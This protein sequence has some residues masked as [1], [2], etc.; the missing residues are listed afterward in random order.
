MKNLILAVVIAISGSSCTSLPRPEV[1]TEKEND[2]ASLALVRASSAKAGNPYQRLSRVDVRYDGEWANFATKVQPV[3]TDREFRV[4]SDETYYPSSSKVR[5]VYRG[6]AGEKIVTRT[7]KSISIVRNGKKVS[8]AEELGAAA[9][10]ADCYIVFT[11]GSSVLL[12]RGSGWQTIGERKLG[13][14]TCTLVSGTVRPG[15]GNSEAD[16]VIAW[17][18][19]DTK[20]LHRIQLTLLGQ[21]STAGADVDVTFDDF[22]PGPYGTEWPRAF[23][24][25]IRRPFDV[26]A[27][28]WRME[29]LK[30]V[31]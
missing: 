27:H 17:I 19:N 18:G 14:E 12:E 31:R 15:F 5:Q 3:V 20:R 30:A 21:E 7:P 6:P 16:G 28:L 10:V 2:P 13:G 25:R 4:V 11:F 29:S 23:D 8:D 9:L 26:P 1:G 22:Q 24:E